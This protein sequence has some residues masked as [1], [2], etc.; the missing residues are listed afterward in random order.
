MQ[1][2]I[3]GF[4]S[5]SAIALLALAFQIV[6][7]PTRVFFVALGGIYS[8]APYLA[9]AVL[10]SATAAMLP[11]VLI[12]I[13]GSICLAFLCEWAN[14]GPL[15]R[16]GASDG[17]Q[18][19]ASLGIYIVTVQLIAMIW[20]NDT[21]TLRTGLDATTELGEDIVVT[22]AQWMTL[23]SSVVCIGGFG[24]FLYHSNLG[25]CL[26]ALADNPIQFALFGY[27]IDRHRLLAFGLGGL[28]AAVSSLATTY[29]IGFDPYAGLHAVLLAVVAVIIGG[30]GSFRGPVLGALLLG[31]LRAEVVWYG[32][33]R[34]QDAATF[35]LLAVFLLLRPQGLVGHKNRLEASQ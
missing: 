30:Q 19:I 24:L 13:A 8:V 1:I 16:R 10:G 22:G 7:L 11:A 23:T 3:N 21:Q 28:F 14:H 2:L 5:G 32:S 27:N 15:S 34:W 17:A 31:L 12:S 33:A 25:L 9:Q 35:G 29:D 20:G 6:Y 26:R 4:I 18:L